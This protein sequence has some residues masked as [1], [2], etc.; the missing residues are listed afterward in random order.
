[1]ALSSVYG[2]IFHLASDESEC[3]QRTGCSVPFIKPTLTMLCN[4]HVD[5]GWFNRHLYVSEPSVP[6]TMTRTIRWIVA[7]NFALLLALSGDAFARK[8]LDSRPIPAQATAGKDSMGQPGSGPVATQIALHTEGE[9]LN[10]VVDMS[11]QIEARVGALLGPDRLTLD[12]E[13]LRFHT[14]QL[15]SLS[16]DERVKSVRF[17]AFM[18]GQGRVL[19]ELAEP[20]ALEEQRFIA[21]PEGGYRLIM[22]LKSVSGEEFAAL[23]KSAVAK[24]RSDPLITGTATARASDVRPPGI[25]LPLVVL[26]PGHGGIDSGASGPSGEQEKTI[27]LAFAQSLK[28]RLESSG[29]I[30][31][32]LTRS[33]DT[34]VPLA[35]RVR[36]ARQ[37]KAALFVSLHADALPEEGDVRGASVYTLSERATD[38]RSQRLADKEN[39]A[40]LV[41]GVENTEDQDEVADILMDLARR[42]S[43]AFSVQFART[44]IGILPR[45][46]RMHKTPLR[47][48]GFKVLRSGDVPSV[49]LELG[50]LTTVEDAQLMQSEEWRKNTADAAGEAIERFIQEKISKETKIP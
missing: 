4:S 35:E 26:D 17:G 34:F 39:K 20:M 37:N 22:Q 13:R 21:L 38:E 10:L 6:T 30:R 36:I 45:A 28:Q 23:A 3:F 47:G 44:L 50:Y 33:D 25:E 8:T 14:A 29:K 19:I 31:V 49:L 15:R 11:H 27:V 41:A 42:E 12:F 32:R 2:L 9:M 16:R 1:L 7:L 43:R 5:P 24:P 40:D 18:R 46:T 48:A